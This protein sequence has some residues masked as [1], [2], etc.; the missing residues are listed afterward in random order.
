MASSAQGALQVHFLNANSGKATATVSCYLI[1]TTI[2]YHFLFN[3]VLLLA[4][5]DVVALSPVGGA[6]YR[7]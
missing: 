1:I 5:N 3:Q 2:V 4:G 7:L 6:V